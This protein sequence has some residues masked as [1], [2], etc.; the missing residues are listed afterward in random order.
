MINYQLAAEQVFKE[1]TF[2]FFTLKTWPNI[3]YFYLQ[4]ICVKKSS[5]FWHLL[6]EQHQ[7][8]W[9]VRVTVQ[10]EFFLGIFVIKSLDKFTAGAEICNGFTAGAE[11]C[12]GARHYTFCFASK[13]CKASNPNSSDLDQDE[14]DLLGYP[15]NRKKL[16]LKLALEILQ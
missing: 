7:W 5:I 15:W 9:L 11:I 3:L 12:N 1:I 6:L 16:Y 4:N 2:S 13:I 8:D 10:N 14:E